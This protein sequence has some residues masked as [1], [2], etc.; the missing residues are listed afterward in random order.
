M[1]LPTAHEVAQDLAK[2]HEMEFGG[3]RRGRM[4][5]SRAGLRELSK[6]GRLERPFLEQLAG[7]VLEEGLVLID[8][9]DYFAL[10]QAKVMRRYRSVTKTVVKRLLAQKESA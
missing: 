2:L 6:R 1:M 3:K 10:I 8:L 7:E 4:R 5:I 9:D